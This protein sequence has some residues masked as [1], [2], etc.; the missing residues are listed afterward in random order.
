MKEPEPPKPEYKRASEIAAKHCLDRY[1]PTFLDRLF[2]GGGKRRKL[3]ATKV[4][5][6]QYLDLQLYEKAM[7]DHQILLH[8]HR[9]RLEH[10]I[11]K[12]GR[13]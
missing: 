6:A 9:L 13:L 10:R 1:R 2:G 3:L 5:N 12:A 4:I 11:D 8:E 7:S